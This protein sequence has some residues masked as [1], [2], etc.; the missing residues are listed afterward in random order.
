MKRIVVVGGMGAGKS[1]VCAAL[2]DAGAQRIDLDEL[3]HEV[4]EYADVKRELADAFGRSVIDDQGEVDR[5]VLAAKAFATDEATETLNRI[6]RP[7]IEA[8]CV[9][10]LRE[11]EAAGCAAAAVEFSAF[12]SRDDA[13]ARDADV[14]VAVVAPV[15]LRVVRAVAHGWGKADVQRRIARQISDE[16]RIAQADVVFDNS[17]A[18]DDLQR[19]VR[20]WWQTYEK[21]TLKPQAE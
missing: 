4:L 17:G 21:E 12:Q 5:A 19:R 3:G 2:A 8:A 18:S 14:V 16:E 6:T 20:N 13:I 11:L 15:Q 10:R 9:S 7:R 1:T